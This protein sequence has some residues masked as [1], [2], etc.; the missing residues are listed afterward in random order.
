[1]RK[2]LLIAF[3][4]V[5]GLTTVAFAQG[6]GAGQQQG[7]QRGQFGGQFGQRGG[8]AMVMSES[9]LLSRN[10][11]RKEINLTEEQK[12]KLEAMQK[13]MQD[14]MRA[15]FQGGRNQGGDNNGQAGTRGGF[16]MEAMQKQMEEMQKESNEKTKA[17]LT[18]EQ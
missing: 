9:M 1:M 13:E 3:L 8:Q 4:E 2:T 6:G 11:V 15:Q 5:V 17:I 14:K 7:G 18:P 16:D 12:T 10:D